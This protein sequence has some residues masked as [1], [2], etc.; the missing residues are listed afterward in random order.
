MWWHGWTYAYFSNYPQGVYIRRVRCTH[1]QK[2]H[3]LKPTGYWRK[4]RYSHPEIRRAMKHRQETGCFPKEIA[5]KPTMQ[6]WWRALSRMVK[7]V[8]GISYPGSLLEGFDALIAKHIIP[9]STVR[10]CDSQTV[11]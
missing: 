3:R 10:Q 4:F 6:K 11:T 1:C 5:L 7:A 8:L 2:V 9:V